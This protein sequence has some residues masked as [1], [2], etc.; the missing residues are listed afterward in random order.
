MDENIEKL[1]KLFDS[2][3]CLCVEGREVTQRLHL[4]DIIQREAERG[5]AIIDELKQ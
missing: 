5:L 1:Y 4:L 3:L 2:I